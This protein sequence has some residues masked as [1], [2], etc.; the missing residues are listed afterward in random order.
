VGSIRSAR[1]VVRVAFVS[2][3]VRVGTEQHPGNAKHPTC[4]GAQVGRS[5]GDGLRRAS[6]SNQDLGYPLVI[7]GPRSMLR[8]GGSWHAATVAR[9]SARRPARTGRDRIADT[10]VTRVPAVASLERWL[11]VARATAERPVHDR[12]RPTDGRGVTRLSVGCWS[13]LCA[14]AFMGTVADSGQ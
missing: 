1:T 13:T 2:R 3:P 14:D 8:I 6:G 10:R 4:G 12:A 7:S 5:L 11:S 9:E